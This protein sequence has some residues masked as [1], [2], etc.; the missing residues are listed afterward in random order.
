VSAAT[1]PTAPTLEAAV[2]AA[3][4]AVP[5]PELPVASVVDLGMIHA[6]AVGPAA[7]DPIRVEVLP[8]FLGCPAQAIIGAAI[9]DGLAGFGR[10]V[11]VET[12]LAVP[13]STDRITRKGRAALSAAGIAPASRPEDV[14]CPWCASARVVMDN[15]F[16]PTPCRSLF[17][18]RD[19]RQ[20]FEA[21]KP[22]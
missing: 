2:H 12:T 22:V 6:V 15:A 7:D 21:M 18:C 9:Q 4:A 1:A 17:F 20:P 13:W 3:L 16:G 14:R 11:V 19:C 5:D 10:P 8:T